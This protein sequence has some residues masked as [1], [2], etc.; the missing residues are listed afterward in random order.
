MN[1]DLFPDLR[2]SAASSFVLSINHRLVDWFAGAWR[3]ATR[4]DLDIRVYEAAHQGGMHVD[5]QQC[6]QV[7]VQAP[8]GERDVARCARHTDHAHLRAKRVLWTS[9]AANRT[10]QAGTE[11]QQIK[12][13][14]ARSAAARGLM[15]GGFDDY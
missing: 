5:D 3:S 8:A 1:R 15:D 12:G 2:S 6:V 13:D 11:L 14:L 10:L 7:L 4:T 9:W